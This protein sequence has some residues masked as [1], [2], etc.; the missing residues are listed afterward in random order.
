MLNKTRL[1]YVKYSKSKGIKGGGHPYSD[2]WSRAR[3]ARAA[4]PQRGV[5]AAERGGRRASRRQVHCRGNGAAPE[6][7]GRT[8][9]IRREA[10]SG[11]GRTA[12]IW[13]QAGPASERPRGVVA[14]DQ[15]GRGGGAGRPRRSK[16]EDGA[17]DRGWRA[18]GEGAQ[19][20]GK[21]AVGAA[22]AAVDG[23]GGR[24]LREKT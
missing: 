8:A 7:G 18:E 22:R 14:P 10:T 3:R 21:P 12:L 16:E 19:R 9:R 5:T 2:G 13:R 24:G 1:V 17:V 23:G 6:A 11:E 20:S 15:A 4:S